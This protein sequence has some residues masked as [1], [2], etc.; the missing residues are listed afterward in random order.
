MTSYRILLADDHVLFREA[1]R[2]SIDGTG[3]LEV[4]GG[5]SDGSELMSSLEESVPDLIILDLTMP[6]MPGLEAAKKIKKLY[7]QVKILILTMH[8]SI[9]CVKGAFA[10]GVNGYLLKEDAFDDLISAIE[11]IRQGK[12][13]ISPR[14]L[15]GVADFFK[16][17]PEESLLPKEMQ[18]L[19]MICE[20]KTD[21]EIS[22]F[23]SISMHT[24]K[25]HILNIKRKLN[26]KTRRQL[27]NYGR[28][29]GYTP[30]FS[31]SE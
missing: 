30:E 19:S 29:A 28:E 24:L 13:Y 9:G 21:E 31:E 11:A 8:K 7:P 25:H 4:C 22:H 6:N 17:A 16:H 15:G 20:Y 10:L 26:L 23:L 3:D 2:K 18:V 27:I 5:V 1:I 14:V 12:D